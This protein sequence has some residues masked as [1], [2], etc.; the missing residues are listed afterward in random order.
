M[1]T[2]DPAHELE[3][4]TLF[5]TP[6]SEVRGVWVLSLFYAVAILVAYPLPEPVCLLLRRRIQRF[7]TE[8]LKLMLPSRILTRD[9]FAFAFPVQ[10]ELRMDCSS[11]LQWSETST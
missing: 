8:P 7:P 1:E 4:Q 2:R 5:D 9:D 10:N 6:T 3:F 11:Q